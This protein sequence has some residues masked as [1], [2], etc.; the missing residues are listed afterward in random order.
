MR[1]R[2]PGRRAG[3]C[4]SSPIVRDELAVRRR[5]A[6]P[7]PAR[8][9]GERRPCRSVLRTVHRAA[10]PS[11]PMSSVTRATEIHASSSRASKRSLAARRTRSTLVSIDAGSASLR[12][13]RP[14]CRQVDV[15][16]DDVGEL[17]R[18]TSASAGR[19]PLRGSAARRR[20]RLGRTIEIVDPVVI[21][22]E[23]ER[24]VA[25]QPPQHVACSI[26]RST[27]TLGGSWRMPGRR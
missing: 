26:I 13:P 24:P 10:P 1:R 6:R 14:D 20:Q 12:W 27:R 3:R 7:E 19:H 2:R 9:R 16:A 21:A 5:A 4:T 18:R 23:A 8:I 25:E 15:H 22:V 17:G 11:P